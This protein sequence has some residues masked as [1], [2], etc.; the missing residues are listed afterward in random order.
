MEGIRFEDRLKEIAL[1]ELM[2]LLA[3]RANRLEYAEELARIEE[4]EILAALAAEE[5]EANW[6]EISN[7]EWV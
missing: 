6:R 2:Q 1:A 3:V 7:G 4:E 5:H